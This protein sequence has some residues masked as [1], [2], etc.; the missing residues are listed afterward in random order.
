MTW[1]VRLTRAAVEDL[2]EASDWYQREAPHVASTF[3]RAVR[4]AHERIGNNPWQYPDVYR[5]VRRALIHRFPYGVFFRLQEER[6]QV[7]A[8]VHQA[9]DPGV[10]K[11]RV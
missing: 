4:E 8:I 5:G 10:W 7:I 11:R 9:R 6:V 2:R 3:R 1:A